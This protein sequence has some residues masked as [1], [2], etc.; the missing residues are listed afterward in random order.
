MPVNS[1][2]SDGGNAPRPT[3]EQQSKKSIVL[4]YL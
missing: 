3:T 1:T 2:S 4:I